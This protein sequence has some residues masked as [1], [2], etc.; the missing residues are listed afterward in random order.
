ATGEWFNQYRVFEEWQRRS[1]SFTQLA[2]LT[3]ATDGHTALW[4][5]RR[6]NVLAIPVS[7]NFFSMLGVQTQ[8]GRIFEPRDAGAGCA[9]VLSYAYWRDQLGSDR[10]LPGG[11]IAV[12]DRA[13]LVV[14]IMP[15]RFSF[16]PRQT[17][18]W[19]VISSDSEFARKPWQHPTGVF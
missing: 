6:H 8:Y 3:W 10:Q 17:K 16:Y 18:L 7:A 2:A 1:K 11:T 15:K 12:D 19:M 4:H 13:C 5:G 14:G 9:V